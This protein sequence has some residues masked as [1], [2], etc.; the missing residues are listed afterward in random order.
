[1]G[2]APYDSSMILI[3]RLGGPEEGE[4]KSLINCIDGY[5]TLNPASFGISAAPASSMY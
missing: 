3:T 5:P 1:M 2:P 4:N